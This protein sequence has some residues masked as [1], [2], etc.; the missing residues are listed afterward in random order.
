MGKSTIRRRLL[1]YFTAALLLYA[2]VVG[3]VF[4]PLLRN[5]AMADYRS[6]MESQAASIAESV[7]SFMDGSAATPGKNNGGAGGY[8]AY[9]RFVDDISMADVW[10]IDSEMNLVTGN[11]QTQTL[12][13]GSLPENAGEVIRNAF[14]GTTSFSDGFGSVF[15]APTLTLGMPIRSGETILGVVLLHAP[16][17]GIQDATWKSLG[18][19]GVSTLAGLFLAVL[20]VFYLAS[21]FTRPIK[22]IKRTAMDLSESR[23]DARTNL[24]DEGEIGELAGALDDLGAKLEAADAQSKELDQLRRDFVANVSHELN[25]PVTVL[26]G[27]LEALQDGIVTDPDQVRTYYGNLLRETLSLQRLVR[28]LLELSRLQSTGFAISPEALD[29]AAPLGDAVQSV[30]ALAEAKGIPLNY[31]SDGAPHPF[32]GDYGRLRQMFLTVLDNAVK[33]SG[34]GQTVDVELRGDAVAIRDQGPGIP[35]QDLPHLFDRFYRA[36]TGNQSEGSG[37][38]LAIA[39]EIADRHGFAVTVES[40]PGQ[41]TAFVFRWTSD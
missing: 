28:D 32:L 30:R 21:S 15:D 36:R 26:R 14:E 9:L 24:S 8:G 39:K 40:T 3:A 38:G 34:P 12:D 41:G 20:L 35:P 1:I 33:Y 27:S 19:L 31:Q 23:L 18:L 4:L 17:A 5:Q 6:Y 7:S 22:T 37:L 25:T 29:L 2:L 10:I 13:F 11:N 16:V